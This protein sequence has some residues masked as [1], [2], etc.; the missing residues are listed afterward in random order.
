MDDRDYGDVPFWNDIVPYQYKNYFVGEKMIISS[1][2]SRLFGTWERPSASDILPR[3][4]ITHLQTSNKIEI[5]LNQILIPFTKP[6]MVW[7]ASIADT[8]S[9]DPG[10]DFEHNVI[11]VRG[12][13][14]ENQN[15][16]LNF[17]K[18]G[19]VVVY[20]SPQMFAIHRIVKIEHTRNGREYTLRG[21]NNSANDP[22]PVFDNYIQWLA[23]A[24]V[25]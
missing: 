15:I 3:D 5:D 25:F 17:I 1:W 19:D 9:M 23:V 24:I 20:Q 22:Y 21:D 6:P 13:D 8:N 11:L 4:S 18:V 14:E 12:V 10:F 7:I 2:L 16:L